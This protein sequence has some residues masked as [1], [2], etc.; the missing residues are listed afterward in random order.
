MMTDS[1]FISGVPPGNN[2][3]TAAH[4]LYHIL[5]QQRPRSSTLGDGDELNTNKH[6]NLAL[7]R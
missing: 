6:N 3:K 1:A 4:P 7:E 2:D 5:R